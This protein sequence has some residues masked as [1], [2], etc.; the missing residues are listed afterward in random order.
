[1]N[2]LAW[3]AVVSGL[4]VAG[5]GATDSPTGTGGGA[6]GGFGG[7]LGGG[8]G[9]GG[10]TAATSGPQNCTG[11]CFN[12]SCPPGSTAAGCGKAGASCAACGANQVCRVDQS[13]GVDPES[14][15]V[16][17]PTAA[18]IAANNNGSAWDGDGSAPD[19]RV[20]M[21]CADSTATST[22]TAEASNTYQPAWS[23]GGCAAKAK[24][25][26]RAGWTFSVYDIDVVSDDTITGSLTVTLGEQEFANG[27]FS[28][29]PTG[30]LT[31]MTVTLTRR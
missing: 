30:G 23:T 29:L 20:F 16:V 1:M 7:G 11:C 24:D 27:G 21:T 15:W 22:S 19:P 26:L 25:L 28:L 10:G 3:V 12:G 6:G 4:W 14:T 8:G 2:R 5:C 13:C 9:S 31:S 17:Q 18:R